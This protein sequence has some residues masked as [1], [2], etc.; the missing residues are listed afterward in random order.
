MISANTDHPLFE[1]V[2]TTAGAVSIRHKIINEIMHNPVGPWAEAN[3]LYVDQSRFRQHMAQ[4]ITTELVIYDVGLGAAANALAALHA[5]RS[6]KRPLRIVSFEID[7]D[8]LRFALD[9]ADE[10]NYLTGF[11]PALETLLKNN[12]WQADSITWE[13]HPGDFHDSIE[14]VTSKCDLIYF[15]PYSPGQNP[16]M[17]NTNTFRKLRAQCKTRAWL[18]NYSQAT[19]VRAALLE[20]GFYVGY[21]QPTGLKNQTTQATTVLS[22][23]D[24]PLD[25][26]WFLRWQRSN[27]P[28]PIGCADEKA[29]ATLIQNHEQFKA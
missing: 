7:L 1:I 12:F 3:A 19:N 10:L 28:Y 4:D 9:H 27:L 22:D 15:D 14:S 25:Q 17:W 26:R 24:Q 13:L 16:Q 29:L 18:Y 11:E 20:A 8:L 23:L 21:G 2:Q 6:F 5:A